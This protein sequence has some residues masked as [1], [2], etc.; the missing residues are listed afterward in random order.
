MLLLKNID[1]Y[2]SSTDRYWSLPLHSYW[3]L[4]RIWYPNLSVWALQFVSA[5]HWLAYFPCPDLSLCLGSSVGECPLLAC[6][7]SRTWLVPV[8]GLPRA[9]VPL[10]GL[11][12]FCGLTYL[13]VWDPQ[14]VSAPLWVTFFWCPDLSECLGSPESECPLLACILFMSWLVSVSGLSRM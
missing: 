4:I 8:S 10:V 11:H 1:M 14:V 6:I 2:W 13:Y 9:W 3:S 7:L 5:A 12:Y